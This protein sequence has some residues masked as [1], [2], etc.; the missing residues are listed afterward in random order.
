MRGV[1][2]SRPFCLFASGLHD[3]SSSI[4]L[5]SSLLHRERP[6]G[7]RTRSAVHLEP[8]GEQLLRTRA[9]LALPRGPK[10]ESVLRHLREQEAPA[11]TNGDGLRENGAAAPRRRASFISRVDAGLRAARDGLPRHT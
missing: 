11:R 1:A 9:G 7:V 2:A 8:L 3:A 10:P 4:K 6:G 5:K